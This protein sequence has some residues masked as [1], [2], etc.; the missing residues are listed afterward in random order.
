MLSLQRR[1]SQLGA[2]PGVGTR[3]PGGRRRRR[4][5]GPVGSSRLFHVSLLLPAVVLGLLV[6]AYPLYLIVDSSVRQV[7][8]PNVA[9]LNAAP[10]TTANYS[11]L[12]NDPTFRQSLW[13]SLLY[14]LGGTI[15]AFL[16]GLGTA[17][18][19]NRRFP[20]RRIFRTL[21]LLPWAVPAVV[22]S[23]LF[24]WIL[25]ASYGVLDYFLVKAHLSSTYIPW[26]ASQHWALLGVIIPTVW[27]SYPFFCLLILAALQS[28][29][30]DLYEAARVDGAPVVATFR[31]ITWPG[32]RNAAYLAFVLQALWTFREFEVIYPMTAGGPGGSTQTLA[33]YL[34]NEAFEFFHMGYASALG[35]VTA[36]I[37]VAFVAVMYPRLRRTLWR[38]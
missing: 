27:K 33:I 18:L 16:I 7:G 4:P 2:P 6:L 26:L 20:L 37:C 15:P 23:F 13:V 14:T 9:T 3:G 36:V 38:S 1:S 29:P 21:I 12:A 19:L 28:I 11:A 5:P 34:Y 30:K 8:F 32:I 17:L 31:A 24:L 22:A 10:T 25:N 35:M